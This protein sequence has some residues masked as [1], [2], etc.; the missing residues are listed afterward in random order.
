[1]IACLG[2]E[3]DLSAPLDAMCAQA[4]RL[5]AGAAE[6][7]VMV[8]F[9]SRSPGETWQRTGQAC[10]TPEYAS[11]ATGGAVD[12]VVTGADFRRLPLPAG[13]VHIQPGSGRTLVNVPTNVYVVV[14]EATIPT[15]VLGQPVRVRATPVGYRWSFGD[16]GGLVTTDPGA[17]YPDLRTT[18]T[19]TAAGPVR[20]GL[21]TT[22]R[23]EYSVAG[24]SWLPV[25][26]TAEVASAPVP[27]TVVA[28]RAELVDDLVVTP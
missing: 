13:V 28:A 27:L 17:P 22:Y 3:L 7:R 19:Y 14:G 21:S 25:D 1:M 24:G 9:Y 11:Q 23:G 2:N 6:I 4:T 18:H 26:G 10:L 8:W 16:G 15:T 12:P 5:C 20:I